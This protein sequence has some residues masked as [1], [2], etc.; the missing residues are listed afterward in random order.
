MILTEQSLRDIIS[1]EIKNQII[2]ENMK[3]NITKEDRILV[4]LLSESESLEDF[5][6]KL[7]LLNESISSTIAGLLGMTAGGPDRTVEGVLNGLKRWFFGKLVGML[8]I[9]NPD[10][11]AAVAA[12]VTE[13]EFR[14]LLQI[15]RGEESAC[16]E[17][18]EAI[19]QATVFLAAKTLPT[20]LGADKNT[21]WGAI[22]IDQF[23]EAVKSARVI[24]ALANELRQSV[25]NAVAQLFPEGSKLKR[26]FAP[27]AAATAAAAATAPSEEPEVAPTPTP[28]SPPEPEEEPEDEKKN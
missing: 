20:Q 18:A 28:E 9:K 11:R 23:S 13:I 27:G 16:Q 21:S 22:M 25:C 8:G 14:E 10:V 4:S 19:A 7:G 24:E 26:F 5:T 17:I 2:L 3:N 1:S 6:Q 12:F 15:W